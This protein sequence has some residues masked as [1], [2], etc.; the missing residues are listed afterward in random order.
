[1]AR[2]ICVQLGFSLA[3]EPEK[4]GEALE[5][6]FDREYYAT[7]GAENDLFAE[8]PSAKQL[9]YIKKIV[10]GTVS[11]R[12]ELDAY[13]EKYSRGWKLSRISKIALSILR[14]ALF[15]VLYMDDVPDSVAINEAVEL[16]KGYEEPETVAF[17][18]GILGS[19]M[20]AERGTEVLPERE[21]EAAETM[22]DTG[23]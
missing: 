15:E 5:S 7:L 11:R 13:I 16:S 9:E 2:E 12:Q 20:R 3:D 22:P 1:M 10:E 14:T 8:Y 4:V 19:F 23:N 18:N 21:S 6:F 17:I